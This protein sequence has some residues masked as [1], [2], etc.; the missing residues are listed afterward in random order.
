[1][2]IGI[3]ISGR[4]SNM[5]AI[6]DAVAS[7]EIPDSTVEVVISD[8]ADAAGF[9]K[10]VSERHFPVQSKSASAKYSRKASRSPFS[11]YMNT[12]LR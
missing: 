1:M 8:K 5:A 9:A 2:R 7:G 12:M 10:A 3:L 4:G 6:I 11:L